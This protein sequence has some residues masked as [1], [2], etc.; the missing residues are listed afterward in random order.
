MAVI[1]VPRKLK[2]K[3][4]KLWAGQTGKNLKIVK[5]SLKKDYWG[6]SSERVWGCVVK[7]I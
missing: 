3:Y 5:G 7:Y 6:D 1:R 4:K 2:K